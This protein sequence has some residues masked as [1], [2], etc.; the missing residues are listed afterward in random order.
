[1][2]EFMFADVL[3]E[4]P[5]SLVKEMLKK[6]KNDDVCLDEGV[7]SEVPMFPVIDE[8]EMGTSTEINDDEK[9]NE[10][11]DEIVFE[12]LD[13]SE[14]T[15]SS[16][17]SCSINKQYEDKYLYKEDQ[18]VY[19]P[20]TVEATIN[21]DKKTDIH[22]EISVNSS[23]LKS[24]KVN[25]MYD[26]SALSMIDLPPL[27]MD[28][29]EEKQDGSFTKNGSFL[30]LC[31][32]TSIN[33]VSEVDTYVSHVGHCTGHYEDNSIRENKV[34]WV[35]N[36]Q[37]IPITK[38][39]A[40]YSSD[41]L[42]QAFDSNKSEKSNISTI[43][44]G[45][46][47]IISN[48]L[49]VH[50]CQYKCLSSNVHFEE[51]V[52]SNKGV[53]DLQKRQANKSINK[54]YSNGEEYLQKCR[55]HHDIAKIV[56]TTLKEL[57]MKRVTEITLTSKCNR[58]KKKRRISRRK[59][60]R[61]IFSNRIKSSRSLQIQVRP[62]EHSPQLITTS[63]E[64]NTSHPNHNGTILSLQQQISV[65]SVLPVHN[66]S[67]Y[68][69]TDGSSDLVTGSSFTTPSVTSSS[70]W[71]SYLNSLSMGY[72]YSVEK[73]MQYEWLRVQS[74]Q[75]F[76]ATCHASPLRL[77]RAGFFSTGIIDEVLCFSC[78]VKYKNWKKKDNP[79]EV[80]HRISPDC[81]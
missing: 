20:N 8:S 41:K 77:A 79:I 9:E 38:N 31:T 80:H 44:S 55:K 63:S 25:E 2:N 17:C 6:K 18:I 51:S 13:L 73:K 54:K 5:D 16:Y 35:P 72:E 33:R 74:Y 11:N 60:R 10:K 43:S 37:I 3:S 66:M 50:I 14:I 29:F 27:S 4:L 45:C 62:V 67:N 34:W 26:S 39:D 42:S 32:E 49:D 53:V 68:I 7:I 1:M 22:K 52:F 59:L 21:K 23:S 78:G 81:R 40:V 56:K 47:S 75:N 12:S 36:Y 69:R 19:L 65:Q 30:R 58:K 71:T 24:S 46:C 70:S 28:D 76:P 15:N 64:A 61:I 57:A 48:K